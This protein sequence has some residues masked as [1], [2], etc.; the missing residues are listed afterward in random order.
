M[1]M[2]AVVEGC[3]GSMIQIFDDDIV[4]FTCLT[5]LLLTSTIFPYLRDCRLG[6]VKAYHAYG[7]CHTNECNSDI[8]QS[9]LQAFMA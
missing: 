9:L 2:A 5:D 4:A 8:A 1:R 7:N 3:L 6:D